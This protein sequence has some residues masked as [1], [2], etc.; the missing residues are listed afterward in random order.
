MPDTA[1]VGLCRAP[2]WLNGRVTMTSRPSSTM[3]AQA[4]LLLRELADR[5]RTGRRD[6]R[7]LALR[8]VRRRHRPSRIPVIEDAAGAPG[9][10]E[11]IEQMVRGRARCRRAAWTCS[12]TSRPHARGRRSDTP[13]P[14]RRLASS[15]RT[16]SRSSRSMRVHRASRATSAGGL[17]P[18][19]TDEI[20]GAGQMLE[21][22]A[23]REAG[24]AGDEN[25]VV[26]A[27]RFSLLGSCS[28]SSVRYCAW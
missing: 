24:C 19:P 8:L 21:Q 20:G 10:A 1:N 15:C 2:M 5:V 13:P 23:A 25:D 6:R 17:G 18:R 9:P 7:I 27:S 4:E 26:H 28:G 3:R 12:A 16:W 11:P 22:V 14:A